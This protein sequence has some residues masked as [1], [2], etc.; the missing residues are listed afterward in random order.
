M[1]GVRGVT[2]G[3]DIIVGGQLIAVAPHDPGPDI[4]LPGARGG[5]RPVRRRPRHDRVVRGDAYQRMVEVVGQRSARVDGLVEVHR[6]VRL[7]DRVEVRD[8]ELL[9]RG[10]GVRGKRKAERVLFP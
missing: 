5:L 2:E 4:E 10:C 8:Q 7:A 6:L 9:R 3:L 1:L